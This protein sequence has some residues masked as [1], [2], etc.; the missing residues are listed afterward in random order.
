MENLNLVILEMISL[1]AMFI[2][3]TLWDKKM[4]SVAFAIW[5]VVSISTDLSWFEP[6]V[7]V[8]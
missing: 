6:S 4:R 8:F 3:N 7:P 5:S 1:I 2:A